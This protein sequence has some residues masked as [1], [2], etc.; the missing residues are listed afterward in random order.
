MIVISHYKRQIRTQ[1]RINQA[2]KFSI[3][4]NCIH[5]TS[6]TD[7]GYIHIEKVVPIYNVVS[8]HRRKD[9][10]AIME[11]KKIHEAFD[12]SRTTLKSTKNELLVVNYFQSIRKCLRNG[13]KKTS[14]YFLKIRIMN[15]HQPKHQNKYIWPNQSKFNHAL[16]PM[17]GDC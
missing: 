5:M 6:I 14:L 4:T 2:V 7:C 9:A 13:F 12:K 8:K 10:K 16:R 17:I 1:Q 15:L 3:C 11:V